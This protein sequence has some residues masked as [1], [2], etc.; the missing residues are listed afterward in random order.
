MRGGIEIDKVIIISNNDKT[1]IQVPLF[2]SVNLVIQN[3]KVYKIEKTES[4][5]IKK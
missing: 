2:G 1:E 5:I 3:G 4:N